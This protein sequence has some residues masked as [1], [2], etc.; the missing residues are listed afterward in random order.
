MR[1]FKQ[2]IDNILRLNEKDLSSLADLERHSE[3]GLHT[4]RKA[5]NENREPS[6]RTLKKFVEKMGINWGW[7]ETGKGEIFLE[8]HTSVSEPK[9]KIEKGGSHNK[10]NKIPFYDSIAVG[11]EALLADQAANGHPEMI[12]PG[13]FLK[14]ATGSLRIYGHSM[15]PKYPA[16]CIVAFKDA[17]LDVIIWGE[18]YVIELSDRRII[19]RVEKGDD[20]GWIK[21][22]SYNKSEEYVYAPIDIPI[23]KIKRLYMVLGKVELEASI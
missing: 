6:E 5:Y 20:K 19:K 14:R 21:A 15:F 7:W 2:K 12:E 23:V 8:K 3:L 4:L 11:G 17:D 22:V 1:D 13:T 18:D 9:F 10:P 16:G